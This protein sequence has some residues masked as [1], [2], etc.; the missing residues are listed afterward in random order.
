MD[1]KTGVVVPLFKKGDWRLCSHYRQITLPS[2]RGKVYLGVM[3]RRVR[4]TVQPRI[5]REQC[6]F[7]PGCLNGGPALHP[8]QC[9]QGCVGVY[10]PNCGPGEGI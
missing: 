9:P 3:E 8:Q 4:R 6:G 7:C 2:L 5:H 1:W 10:P